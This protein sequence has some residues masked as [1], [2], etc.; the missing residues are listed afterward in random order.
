MR[1]QQTGRTL[2]P[3]STGIDYAALRAEVSIRRI[4]E[5]INYRPLVIRGDQWR[6]LC[7]LPNHPPT[8][9]RE[10]SFSVNVQRN[11]YRCFRCHSAGNQ[12]DLW[13]QLTQLPLYDAARELCLEF[14]LAAIKPETCN[15][16][17]PPHGTTGPATPGS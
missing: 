5:R 16:Q 8:K 9:A 10:R 14:T 3:Q 7:P 6:G 17:I 4:L 15:S 11:V 2:S 1:S 12:L 13:A